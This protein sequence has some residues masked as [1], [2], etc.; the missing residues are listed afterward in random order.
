MNSGAEILVTKISENQVLIFKVIV[1]DQKSQ[2]EHEVSLNRTEYIRVTQGHVDP[3]ELIK[4]SFEYLLE[5]E[6]K[7]RILK[8][9]DFTV[10]SRYFPSFTKEIEK[11]IDTIST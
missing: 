6:P 7:E 1:K 8:K 2:T 11:R 4:K 5:N 3:E 10:I 9:F